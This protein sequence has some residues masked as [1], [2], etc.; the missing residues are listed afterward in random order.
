MVDNLVNSI[1]SWTQVTTQYGNITRTHKGTIAW[2]VDG[3]VLYIVKQETQKYFIT[4]SVSFARS[5]RH[6]ANNCPAVNHTHRVSKVFATFFLT[7][8][9]LATL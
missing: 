6:V 5:H 3:R 4:F 9:A 1:Q 8:Y 7:L 2:Q